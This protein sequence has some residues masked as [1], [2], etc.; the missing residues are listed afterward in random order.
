MRLVPVPSRQ[1][2]CYRYAFHATLIPLG[3]LLFLWLILSKKGFRDVILSCAKCNT[4]YR[5]DAGALGE[6]GREVR[7]VTCGHQWFQF[8]DDMPPAAKTAPDI[9]AAEAI[10]KAMDEII[11]KDDAAFEAILS[12]V[13][14]ATKGGGASKKFPSEPDSAPYEES[15]RTKARLESSALPIVTHNPLGV[16]ATAFGIL[17]FALCVSVTL[18]VLFVGQKPIMSHWPQ[19]ALLYKK[20]GFHAPAPGEGLRI[21]EL[22]AEQRVDGKGRNLVVEGKMTNMTQQ[23]IAYPALHVSLKSNM[24]TVMKTW[25]LKPGAE[26]IAAGSDAP[27][28]LQLADAPDDGVTIE[29][30]VKGE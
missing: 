11:E 19:M 16:G 7:C 27:M 30:R 20:I 6:S 18:G 4:Q 2:F 15:K 12:S 23:D 29:V 26:K 13:S 1:N 25:D 17:I 3:I 22:T 28:T 5:L 10:T 21:S 24:D 9:P 14:D 8:P